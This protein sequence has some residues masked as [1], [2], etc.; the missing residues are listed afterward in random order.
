MTHSTQDED[1]YQLAYDMRCVDGRA[2]IQAMKESG[3]YA[4]TGP[5]ARIVEEISRRLMMS[6]KAYK[7]ARTARRSTGITPRQRAQGV[8]KHINT[9]VAV[10]LTIETMINATASQ[11]YHTA[12]RMRG[13]VGRALRNHIYLAA[14]A[15]ANPVMFRQVRKSISELLTKDKGRV[16]S[17]LE[18][19]RS[20]EGSLPFEM[21]VSDEDCMVAGAAMAEL[22]LEVAPDVF[23]LH[24]ITDFNKRGSNKTTSYL[25]FTHEF[26]ES[27]ENIEALFAE[28]TPLHLPITEKPLT[29]T[30]QTD[31]GF[32]DNLLRR[33]PI[34]G[35]RSSAQLAAMS[36]NPCPE[37]YSAINT[38]Q[39]VGWRVNEDVLLTFEHYADSPFVPE[40]LDVPSNSPPVKPEYPGDD[41]REEKGAAWRHYANGMRQYHRDIQGWDRR[42][43]EVGR[44]LY[45][46]RMYQERGVPHYLVH[47]IDFRGRIYP[48]SSA[49]NYQG[50]DLNRALC[51]FDE[52]KPIETQD[53]ADWYLVHGANCWGNDKV[54]FVERVRW[55]HDNKANIQ[56][57]AD[58][59][60]DCTW[61]HGADKPWMF[62]AWCL[63]AASFITNPRPGFLSRIPVSM[64]GSNNGLQIYSLLLR[65]EVGGVATNCAPTARPSDIYQDVADTTTHELQKIAHED[66]VGGQHARSWLALC[67]GKI[68]RKATKRVVMTDVYGSTM[69]SRQHYVSEWYFDIVRRKKMDPPPFEPRT[70]YAATWWLAQRITDA[71]NKVVTAAQAAMAWLRAVAD[72]AASQGV[73]LQWTAPTGLVVKQQYL[74]GTSRKVEI[75]CRRKIKVYLRD[76]TSEVDKKRNANGLCPNFIHSLDAAAAALTINRA[77]EAG[78]TGFMFIHDSYGCHAS[79]APTLARVLREVYTDMFST[80]LMASLAAEFS[81]QLAPGTELPP[82]PEKGTLNINE[83]SG[84]KYFFA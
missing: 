82:L 64:D 18:S 42:R 16:E 37:V 63:E 65:D 73:H 3:H 58:D 74:K 71:L 66:S 43:A 2:R 57:V 38:I 44:M 30:D 36:E 32:Y 8:L 61:W 34:M 24:Q 1:I 4:S 59:P 28:V 70:T 39:G 68:P 46:A 35:T 53:A 15:K 69:Y 51:Y 47:G 81:A 83:L 78:V 76:W 21:A 31:G 9:S 10:A 80:D 84:S 52:A 5:G 77:A 6:V 75:I 45:L 60:L 62:L 50:D 72:I 22:L 41:I 56:A 26:S 7:K 20:D 13:A 67:G 79:D 25:R 11:R 17:V 49:L 23:E 27:M 19:I 14:H 54:S 48:T 12:A 40:S 29:W 55:C 33:R